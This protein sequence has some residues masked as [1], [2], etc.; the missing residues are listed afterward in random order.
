MA[1][2]AP[3][4]EGH[5]II[6]RWLGS[7]SAFAARSRH[8]GTA[9]MVGRPC[10]VPSCAQQTM[11]TNSR[12]GAPGRIRTADAHLRR[13]P[14][15]PLSYGGAAR[16]VTQRRISR[17][18]SDTDRLTLTI[19]RRPGCHLCDDAELLLRDE[20]A[21]RARAGLPSLEIEHM[22]ISTDPELEA[23]YRRR[24]PVFAIGD[25]E[26]GAGDQRAPGP[27]VPRSCDRGRH[28]THS[29]PPWT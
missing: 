29:A 28:L 2:R 23:R 21:Q 11:G 3:S 13:V 1:L 17:T 25:V 7:V 12:A 16:I 24:I 8:T 18:M 4:S 19:Y 26:S 5:F 6:A 15:Y 14:L 22:D 20:L 27:R 10:G 9:G